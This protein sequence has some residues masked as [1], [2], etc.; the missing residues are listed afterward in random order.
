MPSVGTAMFY[1]KT[2]KLGFDAEFFGR[3]KLVAA[4]ADLLGETATRSNAYRRV[5]CCA[6]LCCLVK[7]MGMLSVR[8]E[9]AG[10]IGW[11]AV[12]RGHSHY[13]ALGPTC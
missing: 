2:N 1:F 9:A 5:C 10:C 6:V 8:G 7:E 11:A 4:L 12:C 13:D 3:V